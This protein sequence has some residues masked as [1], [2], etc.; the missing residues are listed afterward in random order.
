MSRIAVSI[1]ILLLTSLALVS[2]DALQMPAQVYA[3][4]ASGRFYRASTELWIPWYDFNSSD[5]IWESIRVTNPTE[6]E[7]KFKFSSAPHRWTHSTS[8]QDKELNESTR[9]GIWGL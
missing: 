5:V 3:A 2:M 9:A 6:V 1:M 4:P 8:H 7:R